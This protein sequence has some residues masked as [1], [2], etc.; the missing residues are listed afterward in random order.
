M[1]RSELSLADEVIASKGAHPVDESRQKSIG[2]ALGQQQGAP[3][4]QSN[5]TNDGPINEQEHS[6][7]QSQLSDP[8]KTRGSDDIISI[9]DM[10]HPKGLGN[11][12]YRDEMIQAPRA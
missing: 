11:Y 3:Q 10:I 1:I 12:C 9:Q 6:V 2:T 4:R 7:A 5:K 8:D